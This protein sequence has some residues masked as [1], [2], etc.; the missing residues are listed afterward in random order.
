MLAFLSVDYVIYTNDQGHT[1]L[2]LKQMFSPVFKVHDLAF[3]FSFV[4]LICICN[5]FFNL[6]HQIEHACH[7][8]MGDAMVTS[9][10]APLS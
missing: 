8:N 6:Q 4:L 10:F 5:I 7:S 9:E 3:G 2:A 1:Y